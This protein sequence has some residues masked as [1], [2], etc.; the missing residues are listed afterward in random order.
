MLSQKGEMTEK[1]ADQ[2][3]EAIEV[4]E[5]PRPL[6]IQLLLPRHRRFSQKKECFTEKRLVIEEELQQ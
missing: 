5:E 2:E 4:G 6:S 3:G 1:G